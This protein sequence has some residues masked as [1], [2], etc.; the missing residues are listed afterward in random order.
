MR[1]GLSCGSLAQPQSCLP[2]PGDTHTLPPSNPI[3][4]VPHV[5]HS[6]LIQHAQESDLASKNNRAFLKDF[7]QKGNKLLDVAI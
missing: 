4:L 6:Q 5:G 2:Y 1:A 7:R 3:L